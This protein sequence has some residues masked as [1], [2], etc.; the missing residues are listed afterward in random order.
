VTISLAGLALSRTD[1]TSDFIWQRDKVCKYLL[2]FRVSHPTVEEVFAVLQQ[3]FSDVT[4]F[5][6]DDIDFLEIET[7]FFEK[8][9]KK[10]PRT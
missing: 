3:A 10:N 4:I 7:V 2:N 8:S 5:R 1:N 6:G 9:S